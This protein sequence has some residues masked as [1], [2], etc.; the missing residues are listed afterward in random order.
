MGYGDEIMA[1]GLARGLGAQGKRAAFGDGKRIIW[2]PWC[3]EIF[4]GNP[5]IALRGSESADNLV[6]IHHYKGHRLYNRLNSTRTHWVWNYDFKAKPGRFYFDVDVPF[7]DAGSR[8]FIYVEPNVPWHKSV[9]PNKDWGLKNYQAVVD[10]LRKDFEIV[11]S[12]HGRDRLRGVRVVETKSFRDAVA[13]LF[14]ARCAL[15]PEGGLHHAAAAISLPAVVIFG[16][17]IPPAVVGY[18]R[19][20]NL[21]GGAEACGSLRQCNHCRDALNRI[22]VEEVHL[23][24]SRCARRE[25]SP[26]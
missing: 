15:L 2:G 5:D 16:G 9:A 21:T 10:R 6:W 1:T 26:A 13:T 24:V 20:V 7:F 12:S 4:D 8:D 19:H 18:D 22:S 25:L 3:E 17:F 14:H 23:A 11:Q